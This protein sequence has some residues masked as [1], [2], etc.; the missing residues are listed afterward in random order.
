M[1]DYELE[2]MGLKKIES[3]DYAG[4]YEINEVKPEYLTSEMVGKT[5]VYW[6]ISIL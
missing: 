6:V 5:F 1:T 4:A 3:G 2:L